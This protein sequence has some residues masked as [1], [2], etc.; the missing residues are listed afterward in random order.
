MA[1]ITERTTKDGGKRYR[2]EVRLKGYPAQSATFRR[3]T[4]A[5]KWAL[6]TET[7]IRAARVKALME[8]AF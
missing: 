4:D 6:V 2:A 3:K 8:T 5:N 1:T 7:K